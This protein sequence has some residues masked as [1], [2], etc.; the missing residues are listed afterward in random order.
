M[1]I[2]IKTDYEAACEEAARIILR[3]WKK[4]KSLVL[5]L[6][7]GRTPLGLYEKL[8][9]LHK[10]GEMDFSNVIA[11]SLDEYFGLDET[12]PQSFARYMDDHLY[13]H[14]NIRP[15]NI[16][17]LSG[18]PA[19]IEEH[20]RAYERKIRSVG[21][22]DIQ[23]LGIGKNGHIGFNEPGSSLTSRTRLKSLT[24][25]T[26]EAN[27]PLFKEE[28]EVP[29]FSLTM[30]IG[31]ILESRMILLLASGEDKADA[32]ARAAEGPLT[33]FVPASV[34]QLHPQAKCILD[35]EAASRLA[36]KDYYRWTYENK[37]KFLARLT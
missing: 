29:R 2:I 35:E 3:A 30:G 11:F 25:E 19:E 6:A 14:I 27:A 36:L 20:C 8:I 26:V 22:I 37:E 7:T 23:V 31:T 21:G 34:L 28:G 16:H 5:G 1:E 9:S 10:K 33:A 24:R 12:H 32:V 18:R 4:R 17:R 13:R 15:E